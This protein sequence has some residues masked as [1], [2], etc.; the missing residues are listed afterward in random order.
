MSNL[1]DSL[2]LCIQTKPRITRE[3]NGMSTVEATFS[4]P[5]TFPGF[6]G[7]FPGNPIVPGIA[8]IM[9]AVYTAT[10]GDASRLKEVKRCKFLH[11]IKPCEKV[12]VTVTTT[13]KQTSVLCDAKLDANGAPCADI[14]FFV[15]TRV[16]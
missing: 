13:K 7:H 1:P 14:T 16:A 9:A 6:D 3:D 8:Q 2:A 15:E 11:P 12:K 10:M 5:D 4:F